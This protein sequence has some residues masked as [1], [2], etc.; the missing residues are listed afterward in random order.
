MDG[1]SVQQHRRLQTTG[2]HLSR[3]QTTVDRASARELRA[4]G[5]GG[6]CQV[7]HRRAGVLGNP[8]AP[9]Q[10]L[11]GLRMVRRCIAQQY[12]LALAAQQRAGDGLGSLVGRTGTLRSSNTLFLGNGGSNASEHLYPLA[13]ALLHKCLHRHGPVMGDRSDGIDLAAMAGRLTDALRKQRM[14]L[15]QVGAHHQHALQCGQRSD[16]R[17]EP[18]NTFRHSELGVAQAIVDVVAAKATHQGAGQI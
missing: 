3:I 5:I 17:T 14:V 6:F 8:V 13:S 4:H 7:T 11:G 18:A 12:S 15:A 16:G 10:Q 1:L 9:C 2:E